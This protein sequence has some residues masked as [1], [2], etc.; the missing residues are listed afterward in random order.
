MY[1]I[2]IGS[3][4][5]SVAN[6]KVY[7][8][9]EAGVA[10]FGSLRLA[11]K[12]VDLAK[13]SGADAVKFQAYITKEF[14]SENYKKWFNRYKSKEV[15]LKFLSKVND[16]CRKKKIQFLLTPHSE[17]TIDWIKKLKI[18]AIKI[19]SGEIGNFLYLDKVLKLNKPLI[20]STGMHNKLELIKLKKFFFK[21]KFNKVIFLKCKTSYPTKDNDVNLLNFNIFK[22]IFEN[23]F[24]GYSDHT[25]HDLALI[26]SI[27]LGAKIVE[28]H[29]SIKFNIKNAQDWKVSFNK[30]Q[31]IRMVNNVRR[32]EKLLGKKNTF[33]ATS[34]LNSKIW[35]SKSIYSKKNLNRN[36]IITKNDLKLLRPGNGIPASYYY[37]IIG[38]KTKKKIKKNIKLKFSEIKF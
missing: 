34:E 19:G 8:I 4:K 26:G 37:K 29:I 12:L 14:I 24:V 36:Q 9:A 28:K 25:N 17:S 5:I 22:K 38:S 2:T 20:I 11:K 1:A 10:H 27:F 3:K 6:N 7:I 13:S 21:K 32:I 35:A 18:P 15:D 30:L 23:F 16:Y 33:L 31:M